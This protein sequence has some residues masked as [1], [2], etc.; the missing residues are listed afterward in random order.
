M[1]ETFHM[2][3]KDIF[4][5]RDGKTV[6]CGPIDEGEV[7][8][9][10]PGPATVFVDGTPITT[11]QIEREGI[12]SRP[13]PMQRLEVRAL[14]TSESTGLNKELVANRKCT[15]EGSM[16]YSGHRDLVGIDS[17]PADYVADDMT[18]GPRLPEGWDGDAWMKPG[19]GGF[20]LRA[21]NKAQ[22]R[23]AL[24]QDATY[25]DARN[26]LLV[27]ITGGGKGVQIRVRDLPTNPRN[28]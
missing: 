20:F 7:A 17:P 25:E 2:S 27:E 3:I 9:V 19:G 12:A 23:Y 22:A 1:H 14:S 4:F 11:I 24:A 28:A 16:R 15:L 13:V 18:L 10:Q 5:L 6:L 21:W 8:L 26:K